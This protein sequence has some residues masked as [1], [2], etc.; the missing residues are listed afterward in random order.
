M[1]DLVGTGSEQV[2][3]VEAQDRALAEL[4]DGMDEGA[5]WVLLLGAE[6]IGKST[7]LRRLLAELE[8]TEADTAI[9]DASRTLGADGL[10]AMLRSR[11][12][13]S[14]PAP[15]S[16]W[17]PRL[18][19]DVLAHQRARGKPLVILVDEA[20]LLARP[21]FTLLAELAA[22]PE[23]ADPAV[24]VVLAGTPALEQPALRAW[25]EA[26]TGRSAATCRLGPLT[27][28]E[29]RQYVEQRLH[30]DAGSALAP[31]EAAIERIVKDTGGVPGL[32]NALCERVSAH[33]SSRL[34]N[35]VSADTVKEAA[36]HLGLHAPSARR[37][38]GPRH[39]EPSDA[40]DDEPA[41]DRPPARRG[42]RR[43]ALVA[44]AAL[45]VSVLLYLG[46]ALLRSAHDWLG[47]ALEALR[48][49]P[50]PAGSGESQQASLRRDAASTSTPRGAPGG[51]PR[52]ATRAR[53]EQSAATQRVATPSRPVVTPASR[54]QVAA[55]LAGAR[56]GQVA[57]LSRIL[58]SGVPANVADA[59]GFTPLMLAVANGHLPAARALLDGGALVNARN[60]GG[61][62]PVMLAVINDRPEVLE[63]LLKRGAD[64]NAQSGTGWTA[65][66]FAAW[67]GDSDLVRMLLG[68]GANPAAMDKQRWTPL[69]YAASRPRSRSIPSADAEPAAGASAA[70]EGGGSA[71]GPV[72]PEASEAR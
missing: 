67:K 70:P 57:D 68:H 8:L 54:E 65:L 33:P 3:L 60:R 9:C 37:P 24:F 25:R 32:I 58:A 43:A 63:L 5:R 2:F 64:V 28:V 1:S 46:P 19:Q 31:S 53:G 10:L 50:E 20:H 35:P 55:L 7:V 39:G 36:G 56:D 66:T 22:K 21:S 12:Q 61:I 44:G 42:W 4:M 16:L 17:G 23:A 72:R 15:R 11:L 27:H 29:A 34:G 69:D 18:L 38:R 48:S 47:V 26:G 30:S 41:G 13:L 6:G 45:M 62:S 40:L 71:V 14:G 51:P 49:A 52:V 59:N